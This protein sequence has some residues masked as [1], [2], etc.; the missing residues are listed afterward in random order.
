MILAGLLFFK[1]EFILNK[2]IGAFLIVISN[3][4][5]FYKKGSF[6][7]DKYIGLGIVANL[8]FTIALF[9][10]VNYSEEFNLPFYVF[11]TLMIPALLIFLLERIKIKD[12]LSEFKN[13]NKV[14]ILLTSLCWGFMLIAQ[15]RAYQLG[16]VTMVAPLCSL[17]VIL[18]VLV[19]YFC[20][21][22]KGNLLKKIVASILI[23][24]SVLLI[25]L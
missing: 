3:I 20:L 14:S 17:T 1:E 4:L 21:K 8:C 9:I 11:L 15:L 18:N 10:D 6:K 25:K 5:V 12:I 24:I 23:I 16:K 7:F 19:G 22:E 13:G 2:I